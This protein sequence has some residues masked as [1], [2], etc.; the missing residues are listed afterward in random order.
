MQK[1]KYES[2]KSISLGQN[3]G[4]IADKAIAAARKAGWWVLL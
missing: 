1:K 4:P 3:Q 2:M